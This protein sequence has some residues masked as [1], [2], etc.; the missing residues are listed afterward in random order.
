LTVFREKFLQNLLLNNLIELK[1]DNLELYE[2]WNDL[3]ESKVFC[4]LITFKMINCIFPDE[5][6][7]NGIKSSFILFRV[8]YTLTTYSKIEP[9]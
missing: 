2:I 8:F 9:S 3:Y 7:F 1:M 5:L 6:N 4:N